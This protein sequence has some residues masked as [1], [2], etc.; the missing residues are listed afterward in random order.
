MTDWSTLV[1]SADR[2]AVGFWI[3]TSCHYLLSKGNLLIIVPGT[4]SYLNCAQFVF[5]LTSERRTFCETDDVHPLSYFHQLAYNYSRSMI[6]CPPFH[7][8]L[9]LLPPSPSLISRTFAFVSQG[10]F[11]SPSFNEIDHLCRWSAKM[12][13]HSPIFSRTERTEQDVDV[14][15]PEPEDDGGWTE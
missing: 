7:Y 11:R 1:N 8:V 13:S 12:I 15:W 14:T 9:F 4:S 6:K 10:I 3:S 2:D 5:S